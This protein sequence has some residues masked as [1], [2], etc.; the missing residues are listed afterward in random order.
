M[1]GAY[2][3]AGDFLIV[4]RCKEILRKVLPNCTIIEFLRK[5]PLTT[6]TLAQINSCDIIVLAG[7]PLYQRNVYPNIIPLT[8]NI[9]NIT[10]P[11]FL[12]GVRSVFS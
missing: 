9:N 3:N 6:V 4:K 10:P 2:I 12:H 11:I 1:S 7:G 5:D 8:D